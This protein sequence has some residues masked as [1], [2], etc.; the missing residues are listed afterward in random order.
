MNK[1]DLRAATQFLTGHACLNYHIGK[2]KG[3]GGSFL[4]IYFLVGSDRGE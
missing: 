2:L 1:K 3:A 4:K